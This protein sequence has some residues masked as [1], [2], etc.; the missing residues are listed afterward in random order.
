MDSRQFARK[1]RKLLNQGLVR[2]L[3]G[4]RPE[5]DEAVKNIY[6]AAR[7]LRKAALTSEKLAVLGRIF[8]CIEKSNGLLFAAEARF[9]FEG[10]YGISLPRLPKMK[11]P[12]T[13]LF[14]RAIRCIVQYGGPGEVLA[15]E[16]IQPQTR[17]IA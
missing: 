7:W 3:P 16:R 14:A 8:S 17:M 12:E 5:E 6:R 15:A 11:N 10:M 2:P 1:F 9:L 4:V 13:V